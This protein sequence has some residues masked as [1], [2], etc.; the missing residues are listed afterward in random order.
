MKTYASPLYLASLAAVLVGWLVG[1]WGW[2]LLWPAASW[3]MVATGYI[4]GWHGVFGKGPEGRLSPW[5]VAVLIPYLL[6]AWL[7]WR[8]RVW[9]WVETPWHEITP[10]LFLGRRVGHEKELPDQIDLV[11]DLTTEFTEPASVRKGRRYICLPTLDG[12]APGRERFFE[13]VDLVAAHDG[14]AYVHCAVGL[15]RSA[16]VVCAVLIAR[17]RALTP[18]GAVHQVRQIRPGVMLG[19]RQHRLLVEAVD[20]YV[21]ERLEPEGG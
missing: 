3:A 16:T 1:G 10:N 4:S 8:F 19:R 9:L 2:L 12:S 7:V 18:G 11:V 13:L 20:R 14:R 6:P 21:P 17:R 5:R 15:G